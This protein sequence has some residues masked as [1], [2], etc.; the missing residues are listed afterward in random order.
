MAVS[1]STYLSFDYEK[2]NE[3]GLKKVI[4]EFK[5]HDV[6]VTGVVATNKPKRKQGVQTKKAEL[7]FKDGQKLTLQVTAQGAIFQVAVNGRVIPIR[8][9]NNLKKAVK[10]VSE[11]I[12]KNS[13]A[14]QKAQ[15]RKM[16]KAIT[17]PVVEKKKVV[18]LASKIKALESEITSFEETASDLQQQRDKL[19]EES[20]T[21]EAS[22]DDIE[23]KLLIE[24]DRNNQLKAELKQLKENA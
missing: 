17:E 20:Q 9:I 7:F 2:F 11:K 23:S 5:K 24:E 15:A 16:A 3:S 1:R 22:R 12:L 10:E 14:F 6:Y 8:S 21:V 4:A 18:N 13:P 19:T